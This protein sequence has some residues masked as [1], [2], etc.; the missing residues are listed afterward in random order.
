MKKNKPKKKYWCEHIWWAVEPAY[1]WLMFTYDEEGLD[2]FV[3]DEWLFCPV[4][5]EER[6]KEK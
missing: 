6:P 5:G 3:P 2:I 1:G 4:C